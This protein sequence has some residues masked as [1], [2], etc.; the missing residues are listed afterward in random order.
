MKLAQWNYLGPSST[1]HDIRNTRRAA[2]DWHKNKGEPVAIKHRWTW[3]DVEQGK[4]E[5][6]PAHNAAYDSDSQWDPYCFGTGFVGGWDD[7]V[8]TFASIAD[9][10]EDVIKLL[11]H[12]Q[13][14]YETHPGFTAP[15][16][17]FLGDGDLL[18][19][20]EFDYNTWDILA[21]TDRYVLQEVTPF[22]IRGLRSNRQGY[23]IQQKGNLDRLPPKH[24]WLDVPYVFDYSSVPEEPIIPDGGDPDNFPMATEEFEIPIF[25]YGAE[26]DSQ[27]SSTEYV[28]YV[29]GDGTDSS[30][31]YAIFVQGQGQGTVI[32]F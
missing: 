26:S 18:I 1:P 19:R 5:R 24:R 11:P 14:L 29:K 30:T 9:T 32:N 15:W 2:F 16:T 22:T 25:V 13:L 3:K 20:G 10:Q 12:G 7:A 31:E 23:K 8:I 6:C 4:T 28:V 27:S 21:E 17:P